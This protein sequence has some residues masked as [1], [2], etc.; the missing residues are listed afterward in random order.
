MVRSFVRRNHPNSN[1]LASSEP[2]SAP[3][4]KIGAVAAIGKFDEFVEYDLPLIDI[5]INSA[6]G[7]DEVNKQS[8]GCQGNGN[9]KGV[10]ALLIDCRSAEE[11][12]RFSIF[13][14]KLRTL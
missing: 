3:N 13:D 8:S 1:R 10:G 5:D 6:A 9:I 2:K 12:N 7:D 4:L 14:P 11:D